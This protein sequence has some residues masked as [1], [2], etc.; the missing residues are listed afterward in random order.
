MT[1][2][3]S[4][5]KTKRTKRDNGQGTITL[6]KDGR[7]ECRVMTGK[8]PNGK[9]KYKSFY[10]KSER[11][12][13]KKLKEYQ[14]EMARNPVESSKDTLA[15][16]MY[17]WL[18]TFKIKA[19]KPASY[20][21]IMNTYKYHIKDTIGYIQICNIKSTD[22]QKL[23]NE[24]SETMSRSSVKK[25][26]QLLNNYFTYL[27]NEDM[28]NK[29]PMRNVTVPSES[30]MN[31]KTKEIEIYSQDDV[32][33]LTKAIYE[34]TFNFKRQLYRYSPIFILMMNTGIRA[35]ECQALKWENID[36]ENRM[37]RVNGSVSFVKDLDNEGKRKTLFIDPK[38]KT[39]N[40]IIPLNNKSMQALEEIINRN[41]LQNVTSEYVCC[42]LKGGFV[43]QRNLSRTLENLCTKASVEFNGLHALRHTFAS[44]CIKQDI[45][46]KTISELLG[47]TNIQTTANTYLTILQEQKIKAITSLDLL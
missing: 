45:D 46:I 9:P 1:I 42:D 15:S 4:N 32:D 24:K 41:K 8:Q 13:K 30:Q 38:T 39:S 6:R 11:E 23:I 26:Y 34:V 28:I 10:G 27:V 7:Y 21:R 17:D 14:Q 5:D 44:N 35:G 33:K 12:V 40:R 36:L 18:T 37:L 43:P 22:I 20:D 19:L 3:N 25:I 31:V 2:S 16:N 29:N 47:H